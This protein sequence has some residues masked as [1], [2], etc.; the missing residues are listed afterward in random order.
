MLATTLTTDEKKKL[1]A[2]MFDAHLLNMKKNIFFATPT[3]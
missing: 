1:D 3:C 2:D